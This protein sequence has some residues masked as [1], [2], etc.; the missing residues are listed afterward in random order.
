MLC[1]PLLVDKVFTN[2]TKTNYFRRSLSTQGFKELGID[3]VGVA[4]NRDLKSWK[5]NRRILKLL[6]ELKSMDG[7]IYD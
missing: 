7:E 3:K 2:S 5:Y 1:S 4:F 6:L